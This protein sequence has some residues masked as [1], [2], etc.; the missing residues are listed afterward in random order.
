MQSSDTVSALYKLVE[1]SLSNPLSS[2][3]SAL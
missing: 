1:I 2:Y 3:Y